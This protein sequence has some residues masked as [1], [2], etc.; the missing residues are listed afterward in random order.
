MNKYQS[1]IYLNKM[2]T[3]VLSNKKGGLELNG[4]SSADL[5]ERDQ[6]AG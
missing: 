1:V 5:F 4:F 6:A 2:K 3:E